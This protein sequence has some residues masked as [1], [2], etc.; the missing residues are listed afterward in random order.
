MA[1]DTV[2]ATERVW[3]QLGRLASRPGG[4]VTVAALLGADL[5]VILLALAHLEDNRQQWAAISD[6][7]V[8]CGQSPS[9]TGKKLARLT[10]LN[11]LVSQ[12]GGSRRKYY[13]LAV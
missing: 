5:V 6:V 12:T 1:A 11:W 4:P 10:E 13:R 8:L 2:T 9:T 7:A 3:V